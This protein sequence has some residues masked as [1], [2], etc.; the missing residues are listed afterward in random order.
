VKRSP[1]HREAG[2]APVAVDVLEVAAAHHLE[3]RV[4]R[5]ARRAE[6]AHGVHDDELLDRLVAARGERA[7]QVARHVVEAD[8]RHDRH[9]GLL[10]GR[11]EVDE[12][13]VHVRLLAR[14]VAVVRAAVDRRL[15]DGGAVEREGAGAVDDRV[16][17]RERLAQRLRVVH[18]RRAPLPVDAELVGERAQLR[19]VAAAQAGVD[20][21][22]LQLAGDQTAGVAGRAVHGDHVESASGCF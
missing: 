19:A 14:R 8:R 17:A 7:H 16:G 9:A 3:R 15:D 5:P 20:P 22:P 13:A 6:A 18:R 12:D 11:V 1:A 2:L 21:A 4:H 10:G